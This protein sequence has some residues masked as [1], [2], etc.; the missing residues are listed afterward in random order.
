MMKN[1]IYVQVLKGYKYTTADLDAEYGDKLTS[2]D[3]YVKRSRTLKGK[4]EYR[5]ALADANSALELDPRSDSALAER[6]EVHYRMENYDAALNDANSALAINPK[7]ASALTVLGALAERKKDPQAALK[8]VD[9]AIEIDPKSAMARGV[10]T[11]ALAALG[12]ADKALAEANEALAL[13]PAWSTMYQLR[14]QLLGGKLAWSDLDKELDRMLKALPNDAELHTL[15]SR[16]YRMMLARDKALTAAERAVE[17]EPSADAYLARAE[18][19]PLTDVAARTRDVDAALALEP[20]NPLARAFR[21][22]LLDLAGDHEG[23]AAH[24]TEIMKNVKSSTERKSY[25]IARGVQYAKAGK[26]GL[27]EADFNSALGENP[28]AW[29]LNNFCRHAAS[30]NVMLDR[31]LSAC[32]RAIALNP[33]IPIYFD[34]K[35]LVLLQLSRFDEAI[36]A[37]DAALA[38]SKWLGTSF[39]GRGM[40]KQRLCNCPAGNEDM[41]EGRRLLPNVESQFEKYGLSV[42]RIN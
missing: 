27:A 36:R 5:L 10:R 14:V 39:Y 35:G 2:A 42:P 22:T 6:G 26:T 19:H 15:A 33:G 40:A 38:A 20:E 25:L 17:L 29:E 41:T 24:I 21:T 32:E 1:I 9:Q 23:A 18:A 4:L 8:Y 31:A 34:S 30:S 7:N 11:H 3:A 37:Y 16:H 28:E 12:K 13:S